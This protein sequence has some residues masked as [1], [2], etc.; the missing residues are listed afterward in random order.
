M[1]SPH[2][3]IQP[4]PQEHEIAPRARL[5]AVR[6]EHQ[7]VTFLLKNLEE[8]RQ[9][10]VHNAEVTHTAYGIWENDENRSHR[11]RVWYKDR[12]QH[13]EGLLPFVTKDAPILMDSLP[14]DKRGELLLE[15]TAARV[16]ESKL[17][18]ELHLLAEQN[19]SAL[20]QEIKDMALSLATQLDMQKVF[21]LDPQQI[22]T[23]LSQYL[24][25]RALLVSYSQSPDNWLQKYGDMGDMYSRLVNAG[26]EWTKAGLFAKN[27]EQPLPPEG[28][29]QVSQGLSS[30]VYNL[31]DGDS[32]IPLGKIFPN[33]TKMHRPSRVREAFQKLREARFLGKLE[34]SLQQAVLAIPDEGEATPLMMQ[35]KEFL[36]AYGNAYR[37][38]SDYNPNMF[39]LVGQVPL[40]DA[41]LVK[42]ARAHFRP[43][44]EARQ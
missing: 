28:L 9:S 25:A 29:E 14:D 36:D 35:A 4:V 22:K 11:E 3:S 16:G 21:S 24:L 38:L 43:L 13:L 7:K 1:D 15:E 6:R 44:L 23:A 2:E 19:R 41:S 30:D 12:R 32:D 34:T 39:A 20:S 26:V 37:Y 27:P 42:Q 18:R 8:D 17:Q 31:L 40:A 33:G 10:T 5:K